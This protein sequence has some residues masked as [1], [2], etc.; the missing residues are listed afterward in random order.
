MNK[1]RLVFVKN[2]VIS[3]ELMLSNDAEFDGD[4]YYEH[5][6]GHLIFAIIKAETT[7]DA[8]AKSDALVVE[9]TDKVQTQVTGRVADTRLNLPHIN[10]IAVCI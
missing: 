9:V 3:C 10:F 6:K 1:Y 5:N 4:H 8:I 2:E 7:A